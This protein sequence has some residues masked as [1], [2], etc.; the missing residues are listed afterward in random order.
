VRQPVAARHLSDSSKRVPGR[1]RHAYRAATT[2]GGPV[3]NS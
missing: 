1:S 3:P 2:A